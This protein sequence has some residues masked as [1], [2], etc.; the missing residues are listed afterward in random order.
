MNV[1]RSI[2]QLQSGMINVQKLEVELRTKVE[3]AAI[4]PLEELEH[5]SF[6][7]NIPM[8]FTNN[9]DEEVKKVEQ[10]KQIEQSSHANHKEKKL[11]KI[12]QDT[13]DREIKLFISSPFR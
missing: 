8:G 10:G 1:R 3:K 4:M 7:G 12:K 13:S 6:E 9:L 11:L 5:I 2:S